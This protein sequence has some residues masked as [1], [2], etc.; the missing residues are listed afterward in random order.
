M[1]L[2]ILLSSNSLLSNLCSL[3]DLCQFL[4]FCNCPT[5]TDLNSEMYPLT[6]QLGLQ[7]LSLWYFQQQRLK[8]EKKKYRQTITIARLHWYEYFCVFPC[9]AITFKQC[10][11]HYFN[12]YLYPNS[13]DNQCDVG[14]KA[15]KLN[16][17]LTTNQHKVCV[18]QTNS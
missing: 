14:W 12:Q 10:Y 13:F 8:K 15:Y 7:V 4:I 11:C 1:T 16:N 9:L 17:K 6:K 3:T 2:G 5:I 18:R